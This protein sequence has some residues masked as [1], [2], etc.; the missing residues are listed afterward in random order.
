MTN[1]DPQEAY[2]LITK[3]LQEVLNPQIIKNVLEVEKR[4]LKLYWGTAPTG[5]PHCGYFVP[6]TKLAHFLK[7]GCEVT[8]L[9]A[10]L[11]AFLDNMKASLDV[12]QYRA[13][14]Y[15]LTIKAILKSINVPVDKLK[16]V[17][18]SSYQTSSNYTMD[19]FRMANV[20]SQNDAKRAGADVVKQV[21]NPLLSGLIYPLM[22]ALDEEYLG[23]DVQFGG[24]DQRKIFVLA[25]ENLEKLGYKK[26]AHLM[27]P[28]VP[29]LGQGGKMSASDPN[30]KIDLLEE[31]KQVKKKINSAFC[32]PGNVEENG[33]LSFVE[34]VVAP[35]Q[36]LKH[37]NGFF[38]FHIDRP[39]KFGGPITFKSFDELK[40]AFKD[41]KLSPPDLKTGVSDAINVLLAP[42]REAFQNSPEYQ[43][44]QAK[45]YPV[46]TPE[47]T[48]KAKKPKNKGT[49]Y[50]GAQ[51]NDKA[52]NDAVEKLDAT[53]IEDK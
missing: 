34:Y 46:L 43:E 32:S 30:S 39:E 27:N 29:G 31:P 4:P 13:K 2:S 51:N 7:A 3:N 45:G 28:M 41:E 21:A 6:M 17:V 49:R 50:P 26:R 15:E 40:Q 19:I 48:K 38:E 37:G 20:C 35:I 1:I 10:D 12:V 52:V 14:Y 11:H 23:V 25:E 53:K 47:K 16:F 42:I 36:E 44:A 24:V 33:L 9:V 5:K 8:V 18:G 22:Q